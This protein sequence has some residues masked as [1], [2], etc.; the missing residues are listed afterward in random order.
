MLEERNEKK[1]SY[2]EQRVLDV[3]HAVLTPFAMLTTGE[4]AP[5]LLL[6][7]F[8]VTVV[9]PHDEQEEMAALPTE[10]WLNLLQT[11]L[12]TSISAYHVSVAQGTT[13]DTIS[14]GNMLRTTWTFDNIFA[15]SILLSYYM[16]VLCF[17]CCCFHTLSLVIQI[18]FIC[19]T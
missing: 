8:T 9:Y 12:S 6:L 5:I 11:K 18:N 13:S 3:E 4:M 2:L 7:S 10:C 14:I 17:L 15:T 16:R 1:R 19:K